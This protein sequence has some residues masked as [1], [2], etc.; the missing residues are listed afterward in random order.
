MAAPQLYVS[1][2]LESLNDVPQ[3]ARGCGEKTEETGTTRRERG[4]ARQGR[5][6]RRPLS[7]GVSF[8]RWRGVL[9]LLGFYEQR[10]PGESG[11][12]I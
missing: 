12:S 7:V 9:W 4:S 8:Q 10:R 3:T 6:R 1:R 11:F 5:Y 2:R